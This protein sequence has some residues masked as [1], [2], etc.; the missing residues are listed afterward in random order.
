M[1]FDGWILK[2]VY[3]L[4]GYGIIFYVMITSLVAA[5]LSFVIGFERQLRGKSINI[6]T[7]VLL[8]AGCALLM[9]MS[10]WAIRIADGSIDLVN[11][12]VEASRELSYDTSRIAA[13]V[14]SGMGFLGAGAIIKDHFTVKGL[15]TAAAL[16][17]SAAIGLACGSGFVLESIVFTILIML[18]HRLINLFN[19]FISKKSPALIVTAPKE[20]PLVKTIEETANENK[21]NI[22][23]FYIIE[24]DDTKNVILLQ[25]LYRTDK[26]LI[27]YY[28]TQ[29]SQVEGIQDIRYREKKG[30]H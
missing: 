14:V 20:F 5:I 3:E 8:A 17:V 29:L 26:R 1:T 24:T 23:D 4:N 30:R 9:T 25:F 28:V 19:D 10:I 18:I 2:L 22:R 11:G 12:G 27:D 16:W 21:I 7:H 13:A 6:K 15:S